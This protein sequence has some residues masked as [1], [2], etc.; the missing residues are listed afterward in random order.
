MAM[1]WAM[2]LKAMVKAMRDGNNGNDKGAKTCDGTATR[3][4]AS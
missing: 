3:L 2:A 4:Q 1:A